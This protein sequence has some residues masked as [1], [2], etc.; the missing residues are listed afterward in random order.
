MPL[1]SPPNVGKGETIVVSDIFAK[2]TK[3][4]KTFVA[5]GDTA[6]QYDPAHAALP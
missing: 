5:V 6:V 1:R 2:I 3:W 4:V